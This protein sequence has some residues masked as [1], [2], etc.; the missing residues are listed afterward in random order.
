MKTDQSNVGH[1]IFSMVV[2]TQV[3]TVQQE[4]ETIDSA[5]ERAITPSQLHKRLGDCLIYQLQHRSEKLSYIKPLKKLKIEIDNS[6]QEECCICLDKPCVGEEIS[7]L[8]CLH[9]YHSKCIIRWLELSVL[10][11]LC[12]KPVDANNLWC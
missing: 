9:A 4:D 10:C 8:P 2:S 3:Y 7:I 12:R 6:G 5:R 1:R 11:P